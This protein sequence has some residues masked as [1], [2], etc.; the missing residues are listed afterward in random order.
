[1]ER[2]MRFGRIECTVAAVGAMAIAFAGTVNADLVEF[3]IKSDWE[4]AVGSFTTLDFTGFENNE[5]LFD[6]YMDLGVTF[7]DGNDLIRLVPALYPND[8][9][10]VRSGSDSPIRFEF[11]TPQRWLAA[12]YPGGLTY[13]LFLDDEIVGEADF[14]TSG[15]GNF[16]GIISDVAFDRVEIWDITGGVVLADDIYFGIPTPGVLAALIGSSVL[17]GSRKRDS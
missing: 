7:T 14:L 2:T 1:M 3:R 13:R 12:D 4:A 16:A 10:G 11:S 5:I 17:F 15:V 8:D 6:Q 9:W